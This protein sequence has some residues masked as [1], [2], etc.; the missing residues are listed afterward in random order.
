MMW[1]YYTFADGM[2]ICCQGYNRWE[3]AQA[4]KVH[5]KLVKV[6]NVRIGQFAFQYFC[7]IDFQGKI[8]YN[9]YVR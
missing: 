7:P 2:A 5:G 3:L 1:K 9:I 8:L 4:E 6:K